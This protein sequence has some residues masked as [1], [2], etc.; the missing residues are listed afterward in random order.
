MNKLKIKIQ[1]NRKQGD[2]SLA[3]GKGTKRLRKRRGSE[4]KEIKR[5]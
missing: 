1:G 2:K 4:G 5:N 3:T